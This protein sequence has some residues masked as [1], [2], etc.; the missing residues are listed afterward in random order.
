MPV[1]PSSTSRAFVLALDGATYDLLGPWMA[2][3]RLPNLKALYESGVHAPLASTDPPLTGPAWATFMTGKAPA[4]HGVL[5]FFRRAPGAYQQTLNSRQD[6]DGRSLWRVLSDAGKKVGVLGVPLTWPPEDVNGFIVTGLLTPRQADVVFTS[7][8]DLGAELNQQLGRYLLH[9][10]EK[11]VQDDPLRLANEEFAILENK[12][13]AALYLMDTRPWDF[14]MLHLLGCDVLQHG[15]W[16]YMDPTHIQYNKTD[17]ARYGH[18]IRDYFKRV[19]ERLP[20]ILNRLPEGTYRMVMSDHGFGPLRYYINFNSWLLRQ[21]FM[22]V[23]RTPLS[24]LRYRAFQ[25]G[26]N[27]R[28]AWEIGTRTGLV[29]RIIH[30]GRGQQEA[31][32]R[33]LFFSLE[34]VD[35]ARTQV[36]SMGNFGQMYVNLA[37]REP[38]GCVTPG[39]EYERVLDELETALRDLRDPRNGQPVIERIY[40]GAELWQGKYARERAPD[41]YFETRGM[42]YKAMG[43]SDFG[44]YSVFEDLYGT[45]AHHHRHGVLMLSGP[46]IKRNHALPRANL[47]DL[48][49]TLY[50]LLGAPIPTDVDGQVLTEAF[51]GGL[52]ARPLDYECDDTPHANAQP[53]L[54]YTPEEEAQLTETLRDLGYVS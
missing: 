8:P 36:Y 22:R 34:D 38:N 30:W 46:D 27:Y 51:T 29:R 41:L 31:T 10:T 11:Y 5:E 28:L 26:Y 20:E 23:K 37:G 39:A 53:D 16:H 14:F 21:G 32:Q 7:P 6:I 45:R 33:Q 48:A 42:L 50:H 3:G 44:S 13:D 12:I 1:R 17:S 49:P 19:D 18:I 4:N 54:V 15:F 43:L 52:A 9:H 47:M 40:R 2:E 35:W 25:L 24:Q